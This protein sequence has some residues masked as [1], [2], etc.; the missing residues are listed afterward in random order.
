MAGAGFGGLRPG[1][2]ATRFRARRRR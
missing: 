1:R 2:S